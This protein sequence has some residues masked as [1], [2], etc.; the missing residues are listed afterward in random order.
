[1]RKSG[2]YHLF[3]GLFWHLMVTCDCWKLFIWCVRDF[4]A[5][6]YSIILYCW[7][8]FLGDLD[9]LGLSTKLRRVSRTITECGMHTKSRRGFGCNGQA[10]KT[11]LG[12]SWLVTMKVNI[13]ALVLDTKRSRHVLACYRWQVLLLFSFFF[14][15]SFS[16]PYNNNRLGSLLNL[17]LHFRHLKG[18]YRSI[19]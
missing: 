2:T 14:L 7:Y 12:C 13:R 3:S 18:F 17:H 9:C 11:T 6:R 16:T 19:L 4:F 5:L 15:Q 1:M 8:L 10:A